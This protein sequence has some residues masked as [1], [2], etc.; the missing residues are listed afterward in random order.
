MKNMLGI[1]FLWVF[2]HDLYG[3]EAGDIVVRLKAFDPV[4]YRMA[5]D[6][7]TQSFP[8][9]FMPDQQT[10]AILQ[11][12]EEGRVVM[13]QMIEKGDPKAYQKVFNVGFRVVMEEPYL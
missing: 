10:G 2:L 13:I 9:Q 7:L 3:H 6:D 5:L 4:Q 1:F 11:K 12:M 8:G